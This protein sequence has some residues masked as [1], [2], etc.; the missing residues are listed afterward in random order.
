[1][2]TTE[3]LERVP[4]LTVRRLYHWCNLGYLGEQYANQGSGNHLDFGLEEAATLKQ[5]LR[6]VDEAGLSVHKAWKI[7]NDT[8]GWS[9]DGHRYPLAP[10]VV[11]V[12]DP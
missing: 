12:L 6:L 11:L 4:G 3:L 9:Q 2:N 8:Q 10:G 5:V 7:T 1:M